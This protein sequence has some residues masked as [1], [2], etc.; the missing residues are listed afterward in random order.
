MATTCK[1]IP[2]AKDLEKRTP[3]EIQ[4]PTGIINFMPSRL[5]RGNGKRKWCVAIDG[6][7]DSEPILG[8]QYY[9]FFKGAEIGATMRST[10]KIKH[11]WQAKLE[12][13]ISNP[14]FW[15]DAQ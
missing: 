14:E 11:G 8:A 5:T 13:I 6:F 2:S 7:C 10:T 15:G 4:G 12:T 9:V 3:F 1:D